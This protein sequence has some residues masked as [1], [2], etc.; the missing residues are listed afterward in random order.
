MKI[1]K[2]LLIIIFSTFL[3]SCDPTPE[4]VLDMSEYNLEDRL[5][6]P[7]NDTYLWKYSTDSTYRIF[8]SSN[9]EYLM[10]QEMQDS[11]HTDFQYLTSHRGKKTKFYVFHCTASKEG[12]NLTAEWFTNFFLSPKP[13]G[14]GWSRVG[15]TE[16]L[17]LNGEWKQLRANNYDGYTSYEEMTYGVKGINSESMHFAYVGGVDRKL[18][19]K[20]T[21]TKEQIQ[22][23]KYKILQIKCFDPEATIIFGHRDVKGVSKACPS[24]DVR[25][26]F[27]DIL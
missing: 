15:Y 24:F 14:R 25:S 16:L 3:F 9:V 23:I 19:P 11:L 4:F 8:D 10:Y 26:L 21:L 6:I 13:K 5:S 18:N 7:D 27:K 20:N 17:T 1:F 2:I 22:G 12:V